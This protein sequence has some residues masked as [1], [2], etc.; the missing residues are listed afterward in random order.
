M[1]IMNL[2]HLLSDI[3][4]LTLLFII[5]AVLL[6]LISFRPDSASPVPYKTQ[7]PSACLTDDASQEFE[8]LENPSIRVGLHWHSHLHAFIVMRHAGGEADPRSFFGPD[9][10]LKRNPVLRS[11]NR[12]ATQPR[13]PRHDGRHRSC[14]QESEARS[15]SMGRDRLYAEETS[16]EDIAKVRA[17]LLAKSSPSPGD[18]GGR[19]RTPPNREMLSYGSV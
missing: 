13:G 12:E 8:T 3:G 18:S 16:V 10:K 11:G 6:L 17:I 1:S 2:P 4:Y 9:P 7:E 15:A 14:S 5:P 19:L